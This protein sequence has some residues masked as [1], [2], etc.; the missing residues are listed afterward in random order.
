MNK[1]AFTLNSIIP[2]AI[3]MVVV[4]ILLTL[5]FNVND[6]LAQNICEQNATS[7][8]NETQQKCWN[9][10]NQAIEA[11]NLAFNSTVDSS[12]ANYTISGY[13]PTIGLVF[14]VVIVLGILL[15]YLVKRF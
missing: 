12:D 10:S 8:Y 1:K 5:G 6:D 13:L 7:F 2:I 3:V 4:G 14:A 11:Q 9:S 15:T